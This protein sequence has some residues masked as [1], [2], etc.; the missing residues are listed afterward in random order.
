[1]LTEQ[2]WS[3]L[4]APLK[5]NITQIPRQTRHLRPLSRFRNE[6]EV[7]QIRRRLRPPTSIASLAHIR[8]CYRLVLRYSLLRWM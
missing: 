4:A 3:S 1:M 7:L 5:S 6:T 8:A 2:P